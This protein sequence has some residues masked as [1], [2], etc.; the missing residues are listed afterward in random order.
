MDLVVCQGKINKNVK[1]DKY[2]MGNWLKCTMKIVI[3]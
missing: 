1:K 3:S 2:E